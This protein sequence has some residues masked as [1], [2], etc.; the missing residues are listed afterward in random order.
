VA[1]THRHA[2]PT[3]PLLGSPIPASPR[4]T[5]PST[6]RSAAQT[7]SLA[8]FVVWSG[9]VV[10]SVV[11]IVSALRAGPPVAAPSPIPVAVPAT[12]S[13]PVVRVPFGGRFGDE[14]D[15]ERDKDE[16]K[17]LEKAEK[18]R[19]KWESKGGKHKGDD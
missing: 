3:P 15:D 16:R 2:I 5:A 17:K 19:R 8:A 12:A 14:D 10:F 7:W 4:F 13:P 18:E 6:P 11:W 9:V 1:A